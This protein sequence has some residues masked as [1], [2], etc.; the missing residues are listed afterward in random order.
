[1]V[2]ACSPVEEEL[3]WAKQALGVE[4]LFTDYTTMLA[5]PDIDAV[6]LVTPTTLHAQQ[7]IDALQAR[8][9]VFSEKPLSLDLAL[10]LRVENEAKRFPDVK[11]MIGFVRRFDAS[12]RDAHERI[13][14]G[15]I[16]TTFMVSSHT[17][18]M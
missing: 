4:Q 3:A 14:N 5:R 17:L 6:F 10:C 2:A 9:H 12:Y 15:A 1:L 16:G 13:V 18:H 8:K 7:I 11:V